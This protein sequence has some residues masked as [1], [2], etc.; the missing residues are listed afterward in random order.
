MQSGRGTVGNRWV[1][2][3]ALVY[4]LEWVAIVPAGNTGPSDPGAKA[5]DVVALYSHDALKQAFLVSWLSVV[6]LGRIAIPVGI[7]SALRDSGRSMVL[8][9]IAVGAMALSVALEVAGE[10]VVGAAVLLAASGTDGATI[11]QLDG[12][13]GWILSMV[14]GPLGVSVLASSFCLFRTRLVPTW[15][16]WIGMVGGALIIIKGIATGPSIVQAGT[17]RTVADLASVGVPAFWLWMLATG[18]YLFI[19][20][21]TRHASPSPS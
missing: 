1:L 21:P 18:V 13:A 11:V 10:A 4:L 8:A 6:L 20:T 2:I 7:R 12:T 16:Q 19:R 15:T 3:G 17:W 5:S 14:W 9:E